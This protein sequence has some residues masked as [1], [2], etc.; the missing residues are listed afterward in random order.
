MSA[1]AYMDISPLFEEHWTGIPVVT[2]MIAERARTDPNIDWRF[3]YESIE[4]DVDIVD[5]LLM[6]RSGGD[7]L[8]YLESQLWKGRTIDYARAAT[9][10]ALFPNMKALRGYFGREATIYHDFSTLLTPQF[11]NQDTINHHANRFLGDVRSTGMHFC[12]SRSTALD[13]INY[14][15]VDEQMV[16]V[17]PLGV[18]LSPET[19]SSVLAARE[20]IDAE[21]YI[22]VLGTIEPRKNGKIIFDFLEKYPQFLG[23]YKVVFIGRDG[24]LNE[25]ERLLKRLNEINPRFSE[26]IVFPGFVSEAKKMLLLAMSRFVVYP[27]FFEGF[28]IPIAEAGVLGK[29]VVC[30][31]TSSLPEVYPERS[32]LFD[33][34]DVHSFARAVENAELANDLTFLDRSSFTEIWKDCRSRSWDYTYE[35]IADWVESEG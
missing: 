22:C 7:Y 30:S 27:S 15:S 29:Y 12:V 33:P 10:A 20:E 18:D 16:K 26:R 21:P 14:F 34:K 8:E 32:F 6:L 5:N 19:L 35:M 9:S 1:Q 17:L 2:A 4:I 25:K 31:N 24:W 13:L 23:K 11:H 28:G 3:I